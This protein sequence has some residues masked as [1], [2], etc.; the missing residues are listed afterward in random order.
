MRRILF[1]F[2]IASI[3]TL[4]ACSNPKEENTNE[5]KGN[6]TAIETAEPVKEIA[7]E[8]SEPMSLADKIKGKWQQTHQRCDANGDNGKEMSKETFWNFDGSNVTWNKFTH[9]YRV[10][11]EQ[12]LIGEGEGSPYEIEKDDGEI[13]VLHAVKTDRYMRLVRVAEQ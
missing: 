6:V 5:N 9:P 1:Y 12:I 11:D 13:I 8:E 3:V 2:S 10:E 4:G 7:N